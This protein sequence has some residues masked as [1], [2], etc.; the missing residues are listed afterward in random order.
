M[1]EKKDLSAY[2]RTNIT[3]VI[4]LLIIWFVVSYVLGIFLMKPL[5]ALHIGGFP[6]GFWFANQGSEVIFVIL[7]FVYVALMKKLDREYDVHE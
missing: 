6:M 2:W 5:N 3:Y 4:I 7:I 1:E